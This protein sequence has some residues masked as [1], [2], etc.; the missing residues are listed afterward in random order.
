MGKAS[1]TL[2]DASIS[3]LVTAQAKSEQFY[4]DEKSGNK[5]KSITGIVIGALAL[6]GVA[7]VEYKGLSGSGTAVRESH[8]SIHHQVGDTVASTATPKPS[9]A[10]HAKWVTVKD[11]QNP[12]T[13]TETEAKLKAQGVANPSDTRVTIDDKRLLKLNHIKWREA[14]NL[15]VGTKLKLL[16]RW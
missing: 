9:H 15:H 7:Y 8:Q 10:E 3:A 4:G 12:Y 1:D 13:I 5:R 2:R 16:K 11:G 6:G 14:W